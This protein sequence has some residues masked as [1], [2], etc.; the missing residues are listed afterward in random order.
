M[1]LFLSSGSQCIPYLKRKG[2]IRSVQSL[3]K[4]ETCFLISEDSKRSLNAL[5]L[6]IR[7]QN[8]N[9]TSMAG[10]FPLGEDEMIN[11]M[12]IFFF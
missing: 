3:R 6:I 10:I 11:K 8:E 12:L 2:G 4:F 7:L 9:Y 1:D 5:L